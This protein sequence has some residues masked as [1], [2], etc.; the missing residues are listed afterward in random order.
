MSDNFTSDLFAQAAIII[1]DLRT[2]PP[3]LRYP[4]RA[5]TIAG[6]LMALLAV[7]LRVLWQ[8]W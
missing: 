5:V 8:R 1:G 7:V 4:F 3:L 2:D 6:G